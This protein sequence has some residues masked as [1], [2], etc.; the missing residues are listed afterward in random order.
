MYRVSNKFVTGPGADYDPGKDNDGN[1]IKLEPLHIDNLPKWK[2]VNNKHIRTK[3]S[4]HT[5]PAHVPTSEEITANKRSKREVQYIR[6]SDK[7]LADY[8]YQQSLIDTDDQGKKTQS[9]VNLLR[10]AWI[11]KVKQIRQDNPL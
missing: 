5:S 3:A 1:P 11:S 9:K 6:N 10:A 8:L 2:I 7:L 4:D